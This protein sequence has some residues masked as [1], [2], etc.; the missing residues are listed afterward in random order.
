MSA[1]HYFTD[2][3]P[4]N[5]ERIIVWLVE[6]IGGL[7]SS[8]LVGDWFDNELGYFADLCPDAGVFW[9]DGDQPLQRSWCSR[10]MSVDS[11]R[12]TPAPSGS[13]LDTDGGSND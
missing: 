8:P 7:P 4:F 13:T 9:P 3:E 11:R 2:V 12:H 5:G 6:R 10:W 1:V